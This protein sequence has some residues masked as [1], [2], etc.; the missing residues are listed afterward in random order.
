MMSAGKSVEQL[1]LHIGEL[2]P[3]VSQ[4]DGAIE[5]TRSPCSVTI[6]IVTEQGERVF[7]LAQGLAGVEPEGSR[8]I[9]AVSGDHGGPIRVLVVDDHKI[10]REGLAGIL[11]AETDLQVVGEAADG[12]IA[13]EMAR[14]LNPHV[15]VMDLSMPHLNGI[16]ATRVINATLP[17]IRII[18]LS[19]HEAEDVASRFIRAGAA[20]FL[21][22]GGPSED[23][24]A[25]IRACCGRSV[26]PATGDWGLGAGG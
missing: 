19:A 12:R 8:T 9:P 1:R 4:L 3:R 18:G 2:E 25:I 5:N 7:K 24:V 23:L 13:I 17:G 10:I 15:V 20:A 11:D 26:A 6:V 21:S 22:K 16:E 14:R